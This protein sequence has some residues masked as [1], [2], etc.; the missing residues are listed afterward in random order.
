MTKNKLTPMLLTLFIISADTASGQDH[1]DP[2]NCIFD[3]YLAEVTTNKKV[4]ESVKNNHIWRRLTNDDNG[5]AD[6][7]DSGQVIS[8]DAFSLGR[9]NAKGK[10]DTFWLEIWK[11]TSSDVAFSTLNTAISSSRNDIFE[12]PPHAAILYKNYIVILGVRAVMFIDPV[13][14]KELALAEKCFESE[15]IKVFRTFYYKG[16]FGIRGL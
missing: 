10:E 15:P 13:L 9:K 12:K 11:L 4:S 14:M 2:I 5:R 6:I 3:K 7:I 8:I 16:D 1:P